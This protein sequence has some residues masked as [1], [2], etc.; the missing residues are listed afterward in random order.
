MCYKIVL[1]KNQI[2]QQ[3]KSCDKTKMFYEIICI[4][5]FN[6]LAILNLKFKKL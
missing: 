1:I 3:K 5:I 2:K 6:T 4:V